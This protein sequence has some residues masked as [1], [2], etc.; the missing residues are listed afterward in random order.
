MLGM[1]VALLG[2][3]S[4]HVPAYAVVPFED[5]V[6]AAWGVNG[7]VLATAIVGDT[8]VVGGTFTRAVSP[9]G[10]SV[11]RVN[12]A[13]FSLSTG[14]LLTGWRADTNGT[15]RALGTTGTSVWVGGDF[16]ALG[17]AAKARIAKL[18]AGTATVDRGFSASANGGVRTVEVGGGD[19]FIGGG[20][21]AV[22]GVSRGR[23]AKLDANTGAVDYQFA[24]RA[25]KPV[26]GFALS[27]TGRLFV[28]GVF[29]MLNGTLRLGVGAVDATTGAVSGPA[30]SGTSVPIYGLDVSPD[31]TVVYGAQ[32][33]NQLTAWNV[34]TGL[35]RWR[36]L[37]DGNGQ[38][39]KYHAGTV[40]FGF[41]DGY[42]GNTNLKLLAVN[43]AT[44]AVDPTFRPEINSFYG[45][46]AIDASADGLVIGGYFTTVSGT[47]ARHVAIFP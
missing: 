18:D 15:V 7:P 47:S 35:R 41:H 22:N 5:T 14:A 34:N 19:L 32:K 38:A 46:F 11:D 26:Y 12:L 43:P 13:A 16:T 40:Y 25:D 17:G 39:V 30:F 29:T 4:L 42:Q 28:S 33:S 24:T 21:S 23:L 36:V 45:V 6:V 20:F 3:G 1:G 27:S 31:G 9:Q 2:L 44:G 37:T 10:T 8:V